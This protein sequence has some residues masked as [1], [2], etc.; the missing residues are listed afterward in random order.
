MSV[1]ERERERERDKKCV[2]LSEIKSERERE[3]ET[4]TSKHFYIFS[5]NSFHSEG[6]ASEGEDKSQ[7]SFC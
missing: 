7:E 3:R 4:G 2:C 1:R 6:L 5:Q